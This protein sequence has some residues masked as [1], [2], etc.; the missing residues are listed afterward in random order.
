MSSYVVVIVAAIVQMILGFLWYGPLFGKTWMSLMGITPQRGGSGGGGMSATYAWTFVASLVSAGV[1]RKFA[2][3]VAAR[4][5]GAGIMLGLL[6]WLGFVAT[7]TLGSVLYEKR[8][9][10]LYILN[11]A[12]Q[13]IN[14][15]VTGAIVAAW[16]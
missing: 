1:L 15:A 8:P 14:L 9:V 3:T 6:V 7:V 12:Y 10:K 5:L 2:T 16:R 4:D 11:N 13:L